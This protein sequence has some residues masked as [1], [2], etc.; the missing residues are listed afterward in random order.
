MWRML[1]YPHFADRTSVN[2]SVKARSVDVRIRFGEFTLDSDRQEVVRGT[3]VVH[4]TPKAL[5]LLELLIQRRPAVVSRQELLDHLWPDVLV[6]PANLKNLVSELRCAFDDHDRDGRFIRTVH[7]RGYAFTEK[8]SEGH[9]DGTR[10]MTSST[11]ILQRAGEKLTLW[12]GENRIGRG[13]DCEIVI[14]D[15]EVSRHHARITVTSGGVTIEDLQSK[16]G[17]FVN[18]EKI[19]FAELSD[20]DRVALGNVRLTVRMSSRDTTT[21]T[22]RVGSA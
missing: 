6:S 2:Q 17:T 18:G 21:K 7:G 8:A 5:D 11:T 19:T 1:R 16:N 15:A 22:G 9:G 4:L 13:G 14:D 20:S 10:R 12:Q 3:E